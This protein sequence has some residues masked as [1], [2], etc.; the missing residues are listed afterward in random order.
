M[1][2]WGCYCLF[3]SPKSHMLNFNPPK[4]WGLWKGRTFMNGICVLMK[5]T[6]QKS[7]TPFTVWG[8][9]EKSATQKGVL[10]WLWWCLIL[11]LQPL[12]L[13]EI[14]FLLFISYS[15]LWYYI[16]VAW[17]KSRFVYIIPPLSRKLNFSLTWDPQLFAIIFFQGYCA[18]LLAKSKEC[19]WPI[20]SLFSF[21]NTSDNSFDTCDKSF[22]DIWCPHV[23][24]VVLSHL[25]D[26]SLL[27]Y[28]PQF[29]IISPY[30]SQISPWK[31][32]F[33]LGFCT[34]VM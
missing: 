19:H 8:H 6:L 30:F 1:L 34:V 23:S 7:L 9:Q 22:C 3:V 21:L 13:W 29:L 5:E 16:K 24:L 20:S 25:S 2:N 14:N 11:N 4:R 26:F 17:T 12:E 15:S 18:L 27:M 28:G 10:S 32:L 33:S 31:Y